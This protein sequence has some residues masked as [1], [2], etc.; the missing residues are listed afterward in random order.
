VV[1]NGAQVKTNGPLHHFSTSINSCVDTTLFRLKILKQAETY[2]D[3]Y[4]LNDGAKVLY[5]MKGNPLWF[6]PVIDTVPADKIWGF[7]NMSCTKQGTIT[8]LTTGKGGQVYEADLNGKVLWKGPNDGK[9]SGYH[10]ENYNHEFIRLANGHYLALGT[11]YMKLKLPGQVDSNFLK[12]NK[13]PFMIVVKDNDNT[14]YQ[15]LRFG[16]LIEYDE[17]SNIVWS[18]KSSKYFLSSDVYNHTT[19]AGV[20]DVPGVHENSFYFDEKNKAIYVGFR[21]ISRVLKVKYPEGNVVQAFGNT[22]KP[23]GNGY[24][25]SQFYHQ[26]NC[27]I[28]RD[29]YLYMFNNNDRNKQSLPTLV[30]VQMPKSEKDTLK[31]IWEYQC[32]IE[33]F[34]TT[35]KDL[36][37]SSL[38]GIV[39]LPDRS[40]LACMT[41]T[42]YTRVFIVNRDK[43]I[44]WNALPQ[45]YN[46]AEH[47]WYPI[48]QYRADIIINRSDL[49]RMIWNAEQ[50]L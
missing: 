36:D 48:I 41:S 47:K 17:H 23:G 31:K 15:T 12:K 44:L 39:E 40:F 26:H 46:T 45:K 11:E 38:G 8:Y 9:V 4:T 16:T 32:T 14:F 25:N 21:D 7:G 30:M 20:F 2:K 42:N 33:G 34:D 18:W 24:D 50:T 43:K 49:E 29:G 28:S 6:L 35:L 10:I 13:D 3:A 37:F 22:Y 27:R 19:P 5:D 1:Y